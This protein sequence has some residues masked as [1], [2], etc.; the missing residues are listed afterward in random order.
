MKLRKL[1]AG[2]C[3]EI[4]FGILLP[5]LFIVPF[6]AVITWLLVVSLPTSYLLQNLGKLSFWAVPWFALGC[7]W[8]MILFGPEP[9]ARRPGLRWPAL[10]VGLLGIGFILLL[11]LPTLLIEWKVIFNKPSSFDLN[12][13]VRGNDWRFL[14]LGLLG[15]ALVG[16]KYLFILF[17]GKR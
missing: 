15:P 4:F 5:L 9:V 13:V 8:T 14:M 16:M 7:L 1:T 3:L 2:M 10:L 11:F 12:A 17:R 6:L